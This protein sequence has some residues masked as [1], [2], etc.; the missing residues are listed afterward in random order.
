VLLMETW[1]PLAIQAPLADAGRFLDGPYR[2]VLHS[3]EGGTY[4]GALAAYKATGNSPHFTASL[5]T[6]AFQ[7]W[8]HVPLD[9]SASAL[10]HRPGTCET[11]HQSAVQIEVV[12][13][14]A[15]PAWPQG[16]VDG[17]GTLVAWI[18]AQTGVPPVTPQWLP[19]PQS[20]GQSRVR[21][22]PA[23]WLAFAG[24][25]GHMHVA[26]NVHGDPGAIPIAALLAHITGPAPVPAPPAPPVE[27]DV[28]IQ[29]IDVSIPTDDKGNGWV[30]VPYTIDRIV[31]Y[32]APGLR[33]AADGR[34]LAGQVAFAA[35]DD[36]TIVSIEEWQPTTTAVVHLRVTV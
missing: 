6:G 21:M 4:A 31:G 13:F 25:C 1:N 20:Y 32:L 9:R 10:E 2:I 17:V 7:V 28:N 15:K 5:E 26:N 35:E 27:V 16:L 29:N 14:A 34:Y 30:P 18:A 11:N 23:T 19:Y 33:P 24:V 8:Q 22:T 3:T 36:H 12:A